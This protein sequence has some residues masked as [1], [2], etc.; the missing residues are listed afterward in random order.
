MQPQQKGF[1]ISQLKFQLTFM[2]YLAIAL[3]TTLQFVAGALW[4]SLFF[5]K[6]WGQIHGFDKLPKATQDKMGKEMGPYY[7]IQFFVTILTTFILALFI[8]NLP[9]WNPYAMAAFFWLGFTVPTLVSA[10]IFGGTE[11]KWMFPK[12]AVQAGSYLLCY[13]IAAAVLHLMA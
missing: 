2:N 6:L 10:S 3:A 12:V 1:I 8:T 4:Y 5:G 7:A 9:G 11:K 13:E